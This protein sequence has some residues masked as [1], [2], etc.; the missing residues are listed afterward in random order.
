MTAPGASRA[1]GPTTVDAAEEL[2]KAARALK[3]KDYDEAVTRLKRVE[4]D[5]RGELRWRAQGGLGFAFAEQGRLVSAEFWWRTYLASTAAVSGDPAW[6]GQRERATGRLAK[7]R[8]QLLLTHGVVFVAT[9]PETAEVRLD[10]APPDALPT[11]MRRLYLV[12]GNHT[13][14][15]S[16]PGHVTQRIVVTAKQGVEAPPRVVA[17]ERIADAV[18]P[19]PAE[20][21]MSAFA[22]AGWVTLGVGL[23]VFAG[24]SAMW[25]LAATDKADA[26]ALESPPGAIE[27]GDLGTWDRLVGRAME[28]RDWVIGLTVAGGALIATGVG[29]LL[30]DALDQETVVTPGVDATGVSMRVRTVF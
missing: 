23:A 29:L 27:E 20:A 16:A 2:R 8:T 13:L 4:T 24:G 15:V 12:A 14:V 10:P 6:Q 28:R 25:G 3:A 18:P 9:T 5:A 1:A 11:S 22:T 19:I 26:V 21:G 30:A 7:V 17:L